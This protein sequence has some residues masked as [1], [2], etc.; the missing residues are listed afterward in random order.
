MKEKIKAIDELIGLCEHAIA[1]P[2]KKK[3]A[4]KAPKEEPKAENKDDLD[5]E[6]LL[7]LHANSKE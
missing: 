3:R 1:T 5:L 7:S 2:T 4:A 6:E